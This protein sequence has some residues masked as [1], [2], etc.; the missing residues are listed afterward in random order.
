MADFRTDVSA[1]KVEPSKGMSLADMLNIQK[2]TY[3]LSK[4]K[5]LY[6]AMISG[7]Q[8]RSKT[9]G[10]ESQIKGIDLEKAT[11]INDERKLLQNWAS[12]PTN[13]LDQNG[14]ID[15]QKITHS[16]NSLAPYTGAETIKK[17]TELKSNRTTADEAKTKLTDTQRGSLGTVLAGLAS[18]GEQDPKIYQEK[19]QNWANQFPT[20]PNA[21]QLAKSYISTLGYTQKG[22]QVLQTAIKAAQ[23]YK[24]PANQV[25]TA[26]GVPGTY[27]AV[28]NEYK[29]FGGIEGQNQ[30][31]PTTGTPNAPTANTSNA[32]NKPSL[33]NA[34]SPV[35]MA[36]GV[37]LFNEQQKDNAA[38]ARIEKNQLPKLNEVVRETDKSIDTALKTIKAASGNVPGQ[39]LRATAKSIIGDSDLEIL[40]KSLADVTV[41][42]SQ[43]MGAGTDQAKSDVAKTQGNPNLTVE[44]LKS[45]LE[46]AKA[47]NTGF[48][49]YTKAISEYEKKRGIDNANA[50]HPQF[51]AAWADNYDP[52]IFILQN[53]HDSNKSDAEKELETNRLFKEMSKEEI[54]EFRKKAHNIDALMRGDYK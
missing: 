34:E 41:R 19:V 38:L 18:T 25:T 30:P 53:I 6:P 37:P 44:A 24:G 10:I 2:S 13:Y 11:Q 45:I 27:N 16:V 1:I 7:E 5:E 14:E 31:A 48:K 52:N 15:L 17:Y 3:E 35:R 54:K 20:D 32:T 36:N 22:P 9:A 29:P 42:Q 33:I 49:N 28:S 50:N 23:E 4:I 43:A 40:T 26:G 46:R 8:A 47:T 51:K 21:Q 12:D 39:T